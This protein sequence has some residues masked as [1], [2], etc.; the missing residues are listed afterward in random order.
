M[1][2]NILNLPLK[3]FNAFERFWENP[4][5]YKFIAITL[6]GIFLL[7]L[8]V[9]ELNRQ[10]LLPLQWQNVVPKNHFRAVELAFYLLLIVEIFS[11][12]LLIGSSVSRAVGKELE[13]LALI[14][15]RN[16]FKT[17]GNMH[18]PIDLAADKIALFSIAANCVAALLIFI[19]KNIYENIRNSS[20]SPMGCEKEPPAYIAA[21]K[22]VALALLILFT[23]DG[24][25]HI[26]GLVSGDE[27]L[28]SQ[29]SFF[30]RFY[31]LL[32]FGDI[33]LLLAA[34]G[35]VHNS[36]LLFRNTGYTAGALFM[37]LAL[38]APFFWD[39]GLGVFAAL[40]MV[41]ISYTVRK[42]CTTCAV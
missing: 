3:L 9:I 17:L 30:A 41:A 35:A 29:A 23:L 16:A 18:E 15:L 40:Y 25:S 7:A 20:A 24:A 37:R 32:I 38:G 21:K 33:F 11:L 5:A 26:A 22:Y 1:A 2:T 13:I 6:A 39:A 34:E 14:M 4:K 36:I 27:S 12:I 19:C 31:T 28:T 42:L 8:V 10:N